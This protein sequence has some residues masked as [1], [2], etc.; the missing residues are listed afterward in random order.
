MLPSCGKNFD[1]K[2]GRSFY[3]LKNLRN[4]VKEFFIFEYSYLYMYKIKI[5]SLSLFLKVT[6]SFCGFRTQDLFK[7]FS[8][9]GLLTSEAPMIKKVGMEAKHAINIF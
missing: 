4:N 3:S 7:N 1:I 2:K 5:L 6:N 8:S 9:L